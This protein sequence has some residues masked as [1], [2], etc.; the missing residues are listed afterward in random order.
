VW[1]KYK[2]LKNIRDRIIH[3]KSADLKS[4]ALD[5]ETI[6]KE[7]VYEKHPNFAILAKEVIGYYFTNVESKDLPRWYKKCVF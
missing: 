1:N 3:I 7:L 4:S 6:W 2:L 5:D